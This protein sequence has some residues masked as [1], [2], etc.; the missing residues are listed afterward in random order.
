VVCLGIVK[1]PEIIHSK[2]PEGAEGYDIVIVGKATD[3]SGFGGA[4][5]ASLVLDEED[6]EQN[7]GA[8]QVPDPFLKNV[9]IRDTEAVFREV[10]RRGIKAGFKDMGAGGIMCSTSEMC[11]ASGFGA[12][13]DLD[14]V[15]TSMEIPAYII[16]CSETQE[17][18][19]WIV[20]PE[21][22]PV[23]LRIYNEDFE[24]P[25]VAEGA[26]A[27][28]VGKVV[29][30][31]RY[32]LKFKNRVVCDLPVREITSGI[33]YKRE[34]KEP[35]RVFSEP[36]LPE[37][38]DYNRVLLKLLAHPNI[39]SRAV[40][41][42]HYDTE[43]QGNTI[44]RP[45]EADAGLI[46]PLPGSSVGVALSTDSNP[47]YSRI[48]PYW[49]AVTAV[50]EAM[51]NVA[52]VGA[53][54]SGI[55]DC[56]N[57]GNPEKPEAFWEFREGVRGV[58][59]AARNL[60]LK[61]QKNIP[62]PVVSGNVSFYNESASGKA[63]DPSAI[64]ACV[65]IIDD[66]SKAVTMSVKKAESMLYF[67]GERKNELGG[68]VY[69]EMFGKLGANVPKI[70]FEKERNM[71]YFIIEAINRGLL[72]SCHDVSDGGVAVTLSEMLMAGNTGACVNFVSDMKPYQFL[73]SESTGFVFE[74]EK[75]RA[76]EMLELSRQFSLS[77]VHIGKTGG[78]TFSISWKG[79]KI[80]ELKL[81]DMENAWKNGLGE[82]MK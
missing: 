38:G 50:A 23:L 76:D 45:G 79:E 6:R 56:L 20:P 71:I 46:A 14:R 18:F 8:V 69:Y 63:V 35:G 15:H 40:I 13:I 12:E 43:V 65:G 24:L 75:A 59:E 3:N 37:P 41:Y 21:F 72:L 66:Y 53:V 27:S 31:P 60:W 4:A 5:F 62:V 2:A 73:F 68:S 10:R 22:T 19:T 36:E 26:R 47:R 51:R 67:V 49:G 29:K 55:T 42:K 44:I 61:G 17:R 16:A 74:V 30:Q 54:P 80:A 81:K 52:C 77:P 32:I 11:A 48:S 64:I 58:S 82:V 9:L 33:T 57:Y 1:E 25:R 78:K 70:D 34:W 39:A 7:R 28:V